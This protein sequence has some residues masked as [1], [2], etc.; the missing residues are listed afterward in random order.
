[1]TTEGEVA[2]KVETVKID[3]VSFERIDDG[4]WKR[5]ADSDS[6]RFGGQFS[7]LPLKKKEFTFRY[8][9][10]DLVNSIDADLYESR[11]FREYEGHHGYTV[12]DRFW[13]QANGKLLKDETETF[14]A[15]G[16]VS[17]RMGQFYEYPTNLVIVAPIK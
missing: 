6:S 11:Q 13:V 4:P 2:K 12:V 1:M 7:E 5:K 9:G 8:V 17:F 14:E 16:S 15:D 10:K 3:K